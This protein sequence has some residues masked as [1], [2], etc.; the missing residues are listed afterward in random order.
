MKKYSIFLTVFLLNANHAYAALVTDDTTNVCAFVNNL[1]TANAMFERNEYVCDIGEYL[2]ANTNICVSC[3]FEN[4]C[5]GGTYTFNE[6]FAQGIIYNH[7]ILS[8]TPYGCSEL[9]QKMSAIFVP[10]QRTCNPGYY[11]PANTD[12]CV[13]CPV[14]SYCTGGTYTFNETVPQGIVA[15]ATGL[16]S[17]MGMWESDQCGRVLHIDN[18]V[19]YLRATKKTTHAVHF[20]FNNDNVADYFANMTTVDVPMHAGSTHKLKVELGGQVYFVYDDT[21][22]VPE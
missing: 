9:V 16:Q 10:N 18:D 4:S 22:T 6:Y 5:A 1:A 17:P 12:G 20:D 13:V 3:P 19:I 8:N 14:N 7:N 2:P 21:V 11:M 15:C